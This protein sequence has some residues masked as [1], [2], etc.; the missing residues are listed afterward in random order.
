V[1]IDATDV[2]VVDSSAA[3]TNKENKKI[4]MSQSIMFL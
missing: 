3:K 4:I 1:V 2:G